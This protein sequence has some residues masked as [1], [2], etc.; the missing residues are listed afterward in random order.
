MAECDFRAAARF[1]D[2]YRGAVSRDER[3]A[4]RSQFVDFASEYADGWQDGDPDWLRQVADDLEYVGKKLKVDTQR[5]TQKLHGRADEIEGERAEQQPP[6]DYEGRLESSDP[7][8]DD[9]EGMFEGLRSDLND[10]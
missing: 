9:I 10:T 8:V 2:A 6:D 4:L 5:Y 3:S 7:D 1:C